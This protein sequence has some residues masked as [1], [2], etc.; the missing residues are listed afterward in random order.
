[1]MLLLLSIAALSGSDAQ[2]KKLSFIEKI[3]KI[4][5]SPV[6]VAQIISAYAGF[7]KIT[8]RGKIRDDKYPYANFNPN[9]EHYSTRHTKNPSIY[10]TILS[11]NCI[12]RSRVY[13][14]L[15]SDPATVFSSQLHLEPL[16]ISC[17]NE[18]EKFPV[19]IVTQKANQT[20]VETHDIRCIVG[21]NIVPN[22][23]GTAA[24]ISPDRSKLIV[25]DSQSILKTASGCQQWAS[26]Q[27]PDAYYDFDPCIVVYPID[28][29][30]T[31]PAKTSSCCSIS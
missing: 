21:E 4:T 16:S 2:F 8:G 19:G 25:Y 6:A 5:G 30:E 3:T 28:Y 24:L 10:F 23:D 15:A 20:E 12:Q 17:D 9:S 27:L 18:R 13:W 11:D 14:T 7:F 26:S 29:E 1:M 31:S 22:R